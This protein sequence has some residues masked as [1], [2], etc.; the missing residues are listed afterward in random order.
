MKLFALGQLLKKIDDGINH[1]CRVIA[2]ADDQGLKL[3]IH[4]IRSTDRKPCEYFQSWAWIWLINKSD[5]WDEHIIQQL[6]DA[7]NASIRKEY[8]DKP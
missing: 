3:N 1:E 4:F 5:D 2:A 6:I 8:E 7:V